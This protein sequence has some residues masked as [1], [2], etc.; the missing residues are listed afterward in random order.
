MML[1]LDAPVVKTEQYDGVADDALPTGPQS[2]VVKD[3]NVYYGAFQAVS[4]VN[5]IDPRQQD[6][7]DDRPVRLRQEHRAALLQPHE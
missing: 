2:L 6:H 3:L 7:G 4:D 5:L 1:K